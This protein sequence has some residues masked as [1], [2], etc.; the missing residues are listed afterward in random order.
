MLVDYNTVVDASRVT[1]RVTTF[2]PIV[3][4]WWKNHRRAAE[5]IPPGYTRNDCY[6]LTGNRRNA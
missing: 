1:A 2:V 5:P 6:A 4:S 3:E